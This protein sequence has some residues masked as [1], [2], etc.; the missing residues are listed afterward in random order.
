MEPNLSNNMDSN[1]TGH[2]NN[3]GHDTLGQPKRQTTP[4]TDATHT[5]DKTKGKTQTG[6]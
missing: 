4:A 6:R 3:E 2:H 1:N 5:K